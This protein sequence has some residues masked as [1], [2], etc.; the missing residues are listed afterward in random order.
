V[1]DTTVVIS[2]LLFGEGR[3]SWLRPHWQSSNCLPLVSRDTAAE[4]VK[5]LNYPKFQLSAPSQRE[6]LADYLPFCEVVTARKACP[7]KC[8]DPRDQMFLDLAHC[9][10]A[11]VLVSGDRDLLVLAGKVNFV[12]ESPEFYRRRLV[13]E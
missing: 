1:F 8:R 13:P 2:A 6:L 4:L 9:G 7:V 11:E 3:L 5:V 12:I 10:T